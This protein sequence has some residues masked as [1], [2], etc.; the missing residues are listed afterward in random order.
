VKLLAD[1]KVLLRATINPSL[2]PPVATALLLT[3]DLTVKAVLFL[4]KKNQKDFIESGAQAL[5]AP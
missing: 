4:K 3:N 1:T 5:T 2:L